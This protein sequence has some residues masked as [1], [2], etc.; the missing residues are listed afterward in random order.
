MKKILYLFLGF[1]PLLLSAQTDDQQASTTSRDGRRVQ[2]LIELAEEYLVKEP[3]KSINFATQGLETSRDA[4]MYGEAAVLANMLGRG[5]SVLAQY[6]SALAFFYQAEGFAE[7][8]GDERRQA[9]I[10]ANIGAAYTYLHRYKQALRYYKR[11]LDYDD[12]NLNRRV[13]HN[14]A[15]IY[16][17]Q[18]QYEEALKNLHKS[19]AISESRGDSLEMAT[20]MNIIGEAHRSLEEF[21]LAAPWYDQSLAIF[22]AKGSNFGLVV[23]SNNK[24]TLLMDE[25][26]VDEA[27]EIYYEALEI[28]KVLQNGEAEATLLTNVGISY[29]LKDD[30]DKAVDNLERA[31]KISEEN[32][33]ILRE[34]EALLELHEALALRGDYRRAYEVQSA[35]IE[36]SDSLSNAEQDR[37]I[38]EL[39]AQ[40]EDQE[41][42]SE[43]EKQEKEIL[44]LSLER[45][46][47]WLLLVV[48]GLAVAA[49]LVALFLN[50][51][52]VVRRLNQRL[53]DRNVQIQSQNLR[54]SASNE[55]LRRSN[56]ELKEFAYIVSH[57]LKEPLRM[58]GSYV[59]LIERRYKDAIDTDGREFFDFATRGVHQMKQLLDDLL[60]YMVV[61]TNEYELE[62]VSLDEVIASVEA[63]LLSRIEETNA[64][65]EHATMPI[66]HGNRSLLILLFQNLISNALKFSKADVPP[67]IRI[68]AQRDGQQYLF[69]VEDN[70]LGIPEAYQEKVFSIFYRVYGK[71]QYQGTGIG[72]S[73]CQK[74]VTLHG[75]RIWVES[76][77]GKGSTFYFTLGDMEEVD[78]W[79]PELSA[80]E[81]VEG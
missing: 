4:E 79:R 31:L 49:L 64:V 57:D 8:A 9:S 68:L 17:N 19:L 33:Y 59:T 11:A 27:L 13:Y 2:Q 56:K 44:S 73:I 67:V 53:E 69:A 75:G 23:T 5:Y 28:N 6:D 71:H 25:G 78:R 12:P 72:L 24:G 60:K 50:R 32:G 39:Q 63:N 76:E 36:L 34:E 81:F 65:L 77:E 66:V 30:Y 26:R 45:Q 18:E 22:E 7:R 37:Q 1:L 58:I 46:R 29:R 16:L 47:M 52:T 54:I 43:L 51:L 70:G 48:F 3:R 40:F 14:T 35:Y 55:R 38:H 74:I 21:E 15:A 80:G 42:K 41:R 20:T 61:E 62:D 10:N